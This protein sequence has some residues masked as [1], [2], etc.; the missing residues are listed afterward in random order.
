MR[1]TVVDLLGGVER[2]AWDALRRPSLYH[3]Y[4]WLAARS[5]SVRGHLHIVLILDAVGNPVMGSPCFVTDAAS[6]PR[7]DIAGILT[8]WSDA[9]VQVWHERLRP[10][11]VVASPTLTGG[12][13]EAPGLSTSD[14]ANAVSMIVDIVEGI[15]GAHAIPVT[16]WLYVAEGSDPQLHRE[17][18]ARSY[19][20]GVMEAE[21]ELPIA[22]KSFDEYLG[23]LKASG[24]RAVL[25]ERAALAAAGVSVRLS[26]HEALGP[27]LALLEAQWRRKYGRS[28]AL[29]EIEQQYALLHRNG[30]AS[31]LR[32]F[33][34][35]FRG[36]A[37][38]FAA[39][40]EDN[41]VWYSRFLGFDYGADIPGVYFN[42]LFHA[43]IEHAIARGVRLIRYSFESHDAKRR[44]GCTLRPVLLYVRAPE[45]LQSHVGEEVETLNRSR[46][47]A[48]DRIAAAHSKER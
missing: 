5:D 11:L 34:A 28:D 26:G 4:D 32:V 19:L 29:V 33:V 40:F 42:V 3:S 27:E 2:D 14:R 10:A 17:L 7:Y 31:G 37:V 22:W 43:P 45:G 41:D 1:S 30:L 12:L 38:G 35:H 48:F 47:A 6:H 8:E 18:T 46:R 21:C 13:V 24:R 15:A 23:H 9:R 36:E 25:R 16:A 44:R 39:F 20:S